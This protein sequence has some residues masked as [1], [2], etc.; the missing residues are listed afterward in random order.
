MRT[1]I[2]VLWYF[3]PL[4]VYVSPNLLRLGSAT[5]SLYPLQK[6]NGLN[7]LRLTSLTRTGAANI[8]TRLWTPEKHSQT[9]SVCGTFR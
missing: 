6:T 1:V 7:A 9:E 2:S 4:Y 8:C 3:A 5:T